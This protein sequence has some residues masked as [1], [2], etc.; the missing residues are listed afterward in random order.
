M[1]K[2]L[3]KVIRSVKKSVRILIPTTTKGKAILAA[4]LVMVTLAG[5]FGITQLLDGTRSG[6]EHRTTVSGETVHTQ[7]F[8]F[9]YY[10]EPLAT[11]TLTNDSTAFTLSGTPE[12]LGDTTDVAFHNANGESIFTYSK[13]FTWVPNT[14]SGYSFS[15]KNVG[16]VKGKANFDFLSTQS[17]DPDWATDPYDEK[18]TIQLFKY[19]SA[20]TSFDPITA[21]MTFKD[22][23][24]AIAADT[25]VTE[26][27]KL[28]DAGDT[29]TYL[30]ITA[31]PDDPVYKGNLGGDNQYMGRTFSIDYNA[32]IKEP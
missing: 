23:K 29:E 15:I 20:T 13:N 21:L 14:K 1:K 16:E 28:V 5:T 26:A 10:K 4:S 17:A 22:A 30:Y 12:L 32:A 7:M 19:N 24:V 6:Y 8:K 27:N 11:D 9:E 2:I 31:F 3:K 25:W 18:M